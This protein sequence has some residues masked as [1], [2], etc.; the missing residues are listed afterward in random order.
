MVVSSCGTNL[1]LRQSIE[2]SAT[3]PAC[4][5]SADSYSD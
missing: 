4:W 2:S 1:S 5:D 3:Y